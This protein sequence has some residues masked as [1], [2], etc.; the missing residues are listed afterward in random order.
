MEEITVKTMQWYEEEEIKRLKRK[1]FN[2]CDGMCQECK[3]RC[4]IRDKEL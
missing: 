3:E 2:D 1:T 4:F